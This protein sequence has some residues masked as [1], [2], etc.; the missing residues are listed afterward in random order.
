METN[1]RLYDI[2]MEDFYF[3]YNLVTLLNGA[4]SNSV[5]FDPFTKIYSVMN[6]IDY[7]YKYGMH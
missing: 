7:N 1:L 5:E 6:D 2:L 4:N 3:F